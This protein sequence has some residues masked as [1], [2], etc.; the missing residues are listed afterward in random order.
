[1]LKTKPPPRGAYDYL[2]GPLQPPTPADPPAVRPPEPPERGG[3]PQRIRIEI[4]ITDRRAVPPQRRG[5]G[6]GA[7][8][9]SIVVATGP[10]LAMLATG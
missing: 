10:V 3:R 1:M 8:L 2:L 5:G 7:V 4:E 9:F 6:I